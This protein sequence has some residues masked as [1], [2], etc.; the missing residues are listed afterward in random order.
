MGAWRGHGYLSLA[1]RLWFF[2][3]F[4]GEDHGGGTEGGPLARS[5]PGHRSYNLNERRR[6]G[7]MTGVEEARYQKVPTDESEAQT[8]AS[9]D[10]DF[11]KSEW[12]AV[13]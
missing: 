11:M 1:E 3:S 8:L 5:Q 9:A 2:G 12:W 10:L 13:R 6:I 7:S 4:D